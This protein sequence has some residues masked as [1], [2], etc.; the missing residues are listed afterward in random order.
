[1]KDLGNFIFKKFGLILSEE[2]L[3]ELLKW[4][5]NNSEQFTNEE[6]TERKVKQYLY[7]KYKG[8]KRIIC[9]EDL[10]SLKNLLALLSKAAKE[11]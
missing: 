1:M 2:E 6:V 3:N 10:S 5:K 9:E 11:D 4:Y 8:R 7:E